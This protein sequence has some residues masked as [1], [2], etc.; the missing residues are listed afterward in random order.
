MPGDTPRDQSQHNVHAAAPGRFREI[1]LEVMGT[2]CTPCERPS[3]GEKAGT[4]R[5]RKRGR[6]ARSTVGDAGEPVLSADRSQHVAQLPE[7]G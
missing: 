3:D 5:T 4:V 6:S 2:R 1:L 7:I